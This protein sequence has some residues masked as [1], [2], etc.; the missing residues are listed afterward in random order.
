M[1]EKLP[2]NSFEELRRVYQT[3]LED[4]KADR[5]SLERWYRQEAQ[6]LSWEHRKRECKR[7]WIG[8]LKR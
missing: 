2:I 4:L 7:W 1:P 8:K 3:R 6:R 5:K